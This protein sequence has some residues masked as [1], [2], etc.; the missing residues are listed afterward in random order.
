MLEIPSNS[1][2]FNSLL[3]FI[4]GFANRLAFP[5]YC[6]NPLGTV[7]R[8]KISIF[9]I[10]LKLS[11]SLWKIFQR[12]SSL[13]NFVQTLLVAIPIGFLLNSCSLSSTR[14]HC[15]LWSCCIEM[16]S[17]RNLYIF[18]KCKRQLINFRT[19][20]NISSG[21]S[22]DSELSCKICTL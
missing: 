22:H 5:C 18:R 12:V 7:S 20:N 4:R 17:L 21:S 13:N 10:V 9:E 2:V 19:L 16:I 1:G 3:E 14:E 11:T 15:T 8:G 6:G